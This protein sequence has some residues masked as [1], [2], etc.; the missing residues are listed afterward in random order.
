MDAPPP[1][2]TVRQLDALALTVRK[3]AA[4]YLNAVE[5]VRELVEADAQQKGVSPG[6]P[7]THEKTD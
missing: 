5:L 1:P 3:R 2:I 6:D 7:P 4:K